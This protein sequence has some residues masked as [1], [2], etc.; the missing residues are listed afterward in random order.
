MRFTKTLCIL[1][2]NFS[3]LVSTQAQKI[4]STTNKTWV[5]NNV[6]QSKFWGNSWYT[7]ASFNWSN[8]LEL[9]VN[10][11][12]TYGKEYKGESL[13]MYTMKSWGLG[14]GLAH[15]ADGINRQIAKAFM[16]RCLFSFPPLSFGI[17]GDYIYNLTDNKHYL[18]PSIGAS[19][20]YFDLMYNYSFLLNTSGNENDFKSGLTFRFKYYFGMKNW[21]KNTAKR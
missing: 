8:S 12:R 2:F 16:E 1:L 15:G 7:A 3:L 20:M 4:D 10:I 17:R 9:D 11:G 6:P 19:F 18:R 13:S 21:Q 14:Y 5:M